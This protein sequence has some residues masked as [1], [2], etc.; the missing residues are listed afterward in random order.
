MKSRNKRHEMQVI[1]YHSH[2]RKIGDKTI[3]EKHF[4]FRLLMVELRC[5]IAMLNRNVQG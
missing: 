3:G 4:V 2:H 1:I 5:E